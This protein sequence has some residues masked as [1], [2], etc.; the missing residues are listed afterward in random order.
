MI[1]SILSGLSNVIFIHLIHRHGLKQGNLLM[2]W[3]TTVI[4]NIG[5]YVLGVPVYA[6]LSMHQDSCSG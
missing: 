3:I 5:L 4:I 2:L 6:Y 1:L